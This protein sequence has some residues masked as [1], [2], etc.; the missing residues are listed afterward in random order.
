MTENPEKLYTKLVERLRGMK[1][2]CVAFSGGVDST[3]L[4]HAA[5]EALGDSA[6]AVTVKCM[7]IPPEETL[8]AADYA[9]SYGFS[10]SVIDI[11]FSLVPGFI[12]N[13]R[14][15]CYHC[16]KAIFNAI[17][18]HAKNL[19]IMN[20]IEGSHTA[21]ITDYRPGM[22]ALKELKISSPF[23]DAGMNKDDIINISQAMELQG[24][25]RPSSSCLATRIEYGTAIDPV[26]LLRIHDA[27]KLL[28]SSGFKQV[29]VR[30]HGSIARIEVEAAAAAALMQTGTI[31]KII[32]SVKSAGF[33]YVTVDLEGYRQGSMN[34]GI[35]ESQDE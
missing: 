12:E 3:L 7:M 17:L 13:S 32:A 24:C 30:A 1:S 19:N 25:G 22:K 18:T 2:V 16:K 9:R 33:I 6:A 31:E 20:V 11:D 35:M 23:I 29:R 14:L 15:R 8:Y 10:H 4:L 5:R 26:Q 21:D 27:E 28:R 34:S